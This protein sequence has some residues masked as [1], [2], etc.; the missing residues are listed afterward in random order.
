MRLFQ[1]I[2]FPFSWPKTQFLE[3]KWWHRLA[4]VLFIIVLIVSLFFV[5]LHKSDEFSYLIKPIPY[6]DYVKRKSLDETSA[7]S[8]FSTAIRVKYP[9]RI[10]DTNW[11]IWRYFFTLEPNANDLLLK[12]I[13]YWDRD[14]FFA[15]GIYSKPY[16]PH[17]SPS[18]YVKYISKVIRSVFSGLIIMYFVSIFCQIIYFRWIVYV[19]YGNKWK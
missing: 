13:N 8:E 14:L 17:G 5:Y 7:I 15:A 18:Y 16:P 10:N 6:S 1:K 12:Y 2:L 19:I 4:K 3:N 9:N 11:D